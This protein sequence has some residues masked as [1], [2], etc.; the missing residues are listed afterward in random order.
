ME[1]LAR[2]PYSFSISFLQE[3]KLVGDEDPL[4]QNKYKLN[5]DWDSLTE[6]TKCIEATKVVE[7]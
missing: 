5:L 2:N 7:Q 3:V 6:F 1:K 4:A